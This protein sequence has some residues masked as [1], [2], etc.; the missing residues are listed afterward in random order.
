MGLITYMRTD[1]TR[2]SPD[3]IDAIR[4]HV[5]KKLGDKYIPETPNV[6]KSKKDAQDAHEAIRPTN[7]AWTPEL[8]ALSERRAVSAV[9]ADL[10]ARGDQPDDAGGV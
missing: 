3:A 5:K 7:I 6:Y 2:M 8:C 10:G 4:E 1:S 9:L